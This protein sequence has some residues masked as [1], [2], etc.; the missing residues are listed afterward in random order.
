[1]PILKRH[2]ISGCDSQPHSIDTCL[3]KEPE[4]IVDTQHIGE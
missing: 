3:D 1:M 4:E 2:L